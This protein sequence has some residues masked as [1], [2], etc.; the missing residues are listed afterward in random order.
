M[1]RLLFVP[2]VKRSKTVCG[3]EVEGSSLLLAKPA[4]VLGLILFPFPFPL[5]LLLIELF[6]IPLEVLG[7]LMLVAV[8]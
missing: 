3:T 8:A 7:L 6:A 4:D 1:R 5:L 2:K